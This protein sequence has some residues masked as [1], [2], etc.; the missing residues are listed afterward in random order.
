[1]TLPQ[2]FSCTPPFKSLGY[3]FLKDIDTFIQQTLNNKKV[4]VQT[5]IILQLSIIKES[6]K[7][8]KIGFQT[9]FNIDNHKTFL[10]QQIGI[11]E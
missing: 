4:T 5:F 9:D 6:Q 10:T 7:S 8:T 2:K 1:M 3:L 11:S